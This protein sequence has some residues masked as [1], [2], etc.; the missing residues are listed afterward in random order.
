MAHFPSSNHAPPNSEKEGEECQRSGTHATTQ[1]LSGSVDWTDVRD[2]G[3]SCL[4]SDAFILSSVAPMGGGTS[5][6]LAPPSQQQGSKEAQQGSE[7]AQQGSKEAQENS[8]Q[9]AQQQGAP[10][11]KS[12]GGGSQSCGISGEIR[13][14][15][16]GRPEAT[17][18]GASQ[19]LDGGERD[20]GVGEG[21]VARFGPGL[22]GS[23]F[24]QEVP[25]GVYS[26]RLGSS[27][28]GKLRGGGGGGGGG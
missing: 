13:S 3:G 7:E 18:S 22:Q 23:S 24:W 5:S 4:P 26:L 14:G 25:P 15:E 28:G 11:A 8:N 17:R 9:H 16:R 21:E 19:E 27:R 20:D 2:S 6:A 1:H 12:G 10:L